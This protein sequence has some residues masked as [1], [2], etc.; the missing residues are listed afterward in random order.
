[1][2]AGQYRT[3]G[4]V[5]G[6]AVLA[7]MLLTLAALL[8]GHE[9]AQ[10]SAPMVTAVVLSSDAGNDDTC[11]LDDVIRVTVTFSQAVDVTGNPQV[12]P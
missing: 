7:V 9:Q 10:S 8:L 2:V 6:L 1:M 12:K 3:V 5:M 11:V 4:S